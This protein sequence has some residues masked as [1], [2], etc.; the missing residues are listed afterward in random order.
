M[1]SPT[2]VQKKK[3]GS[4]EERQLQQ[5]LQVRSACLPL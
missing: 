5:M 2:A 1:V 4:G 3:Y